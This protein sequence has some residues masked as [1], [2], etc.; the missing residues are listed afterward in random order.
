MDLSA[1]LKEV[2]KLP[3]E[4][5]FRLI[6]AVWDKLLDLGFSLELT[7]DQRKELD[8]RVAKHEQDPTQAISWET[9]RDGYRQQ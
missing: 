7:P 2:E 3:I 9:I 1:T 5:R 8:S 4:D 6:E